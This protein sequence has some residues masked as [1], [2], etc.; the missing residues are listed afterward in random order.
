M[1]QNNL[2]YLEQQTFQ[3]KTILIDGSNFLLNRNSSLQKFQFLISLIR[4]FEPKEVI[5]IC[6]ANLPYKIDITKLLKDKLIQL[7]PAGTQADIFLIQLANH[8]PDALII[9]NDLFREYDHAFTR[10]INFV[11]YFIVGDRI[12]FNLDLTKKQEISI[13]KQI[14]KKPEIEENSNYEFLDRIFKST[15]EIKLYS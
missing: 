4:D 3:N 15:G 7:T 1:T 8:L 6:D 13:N 5:T 12:L 2:Y 14:E 11:R 10:N 9:T